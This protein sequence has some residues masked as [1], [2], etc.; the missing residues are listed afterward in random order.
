M[1]KRDASSANSFTVDEGLLPRSFL[2]IRK[3][4]GPKKEP[5][6][7][8]ASID[9]HEDAWPFKRTD[10]NLPFKKLLMRSQLINFYKLIL[11]ARP[12]QKL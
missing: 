9:H 7:T 11:Y 5:W 10:W 6:G 12:Y 3:N 1:E 2:Y 4:S 8:P